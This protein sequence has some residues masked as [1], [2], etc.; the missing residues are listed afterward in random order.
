MDYS[1]ERWIN[2][3]ARS[4]PLWDALMF[5]FSAGS[6]PAFAALVGIWF[7]A[8]W[9]RGLSKDRQGAIAALL[10]AGGAL[11]VNQV[12]AALWDRPRP[13]VAHPNQVHHLLAHG[14]D[15]S[16]P[17]DHA[18]AAFAIATVLFAH[19]R[20]LG[21]VALAAAAVV[22]YARVYVGDHYPSDV[23][24]GAAIGVVAGLALVR[25]F[26]AVPRLA[27]KIVDAVMVRLRLLR[28][29]G[30]RRAL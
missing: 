17:S 20:R 29:P 2:A 30:E 7:L 5:G 6:E 24:S 1:L 15:G 13:F 11:A 16:F 22:G 4:H 25:W 23:L 12:L 28:E 18:A 21:L 10:A 9:L 27:L 14:A 3:P 26:P 8:G 19:H